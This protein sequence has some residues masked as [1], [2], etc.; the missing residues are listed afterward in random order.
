[1]IQGQVAAG[2]MR[3]PTSVELGGTKQLKKNWDLKEINEVLKVSTTCF[4]TELNP[5]H[6]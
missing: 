6:R 1:M 4:A 5:R 3:V 2:T